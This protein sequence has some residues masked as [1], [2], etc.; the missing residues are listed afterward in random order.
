[1]RLRGFLTSESGISD[2]VSANLNPQ[3]LIQLLNPFGD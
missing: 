3:F 2:S 1:L